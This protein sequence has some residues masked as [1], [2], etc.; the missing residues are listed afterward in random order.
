MKNGNIINKSAL[1]SALNTRSMY[2]GSVILS[3]S[4]MAI[5]ISSIYAGPYTDSAHGN[6]SYGVNRS[7]IA[8]FNYSRGNCAHCHEQHASMGGSEPVPVSGNASKQLIFYSAYISQ[9]D[10][11]CYQCHQT[12]SIQTGMPMQYSYSY[13]YGGDNSISCPDSIKDAFI[14]INDDGSH[15]PNCGSSTGSSHQL[16]VIK[17]FITNKW[18]FGS[19]PINPCSGCHNTHRTQRASYPVEVKGASPISLP[20]SHASDW[21]LWGDDATERMSNYTSNYQAPYYYNSTTTYEPNGDTIM[22]GSN[23]PDYVT[24]CTDCHNTSNDGLISSSQKYN[25]TGNWQAALYNPDWEST[26]PHGKISGKMNHMTDINAPYNA[27]NTNYVLSCTDCHEPHGSSNGMLI[28]QEVNGSSTVNFTSWASRDDWFTLCLR[29]HQTPNG[30][31]MGAKLN[32][33]YTCHM[34]N[35]NSNKPI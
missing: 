32:P 7:S 29:C 4:L 21:E 30:H 15:N 8:S 27:T 12:G 16:A 33:C 2:F 20:S 11:F 6:T 34:H 24:F 14:F 13:K 9:S 17:N 10:M 18:G 3:I 23:M 35:I 31:N 25:F 5:W 1:R 26:S 22:N 19:N 28:R